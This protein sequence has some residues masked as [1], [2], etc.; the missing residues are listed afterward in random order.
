MAEKSG[1]SF[2]DKEVMLIPLVASDRPPAVSKVKLQ[3]GHHVTKAVSK[4]HGASPSFFHADT[5]QLLAQLKTETLA[6]NPPAGPSA[7]FSID[8][9]DSLRSNPV[10]GVLA[11]FTHW[12][13]ATQT[14][15]VPVLRVVA[16]PAVATVGTFNVSEPPGFNLQEAWDPSVFPADFLPDSDCSCPVMVSGGSFSRQTDPPTLDNFLKTTD[17][18]FLPSGEKLAFSIGI[19]DACFLRAFHLPAH[20]HLPIGMAWQ[21]GGL[22]TDVLLRS[23][24]ALTS[25]NG[26]VA[27]QPFQSAL[28]LLAPALTLGS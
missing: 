23:V 13:S 10:G 14:F 2:G 18:L 28:T 20:S 17:P 7:G 15:G 3:H 11:I 16:C 19:G 22:T 4:H 24:K 9:F 6:W 8:R 1:F 21:L 12:N 27:Y 5:T 25:K 26:H